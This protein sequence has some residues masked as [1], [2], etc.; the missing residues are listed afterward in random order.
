[1]A[2]DSYFMVLPENDAMRIDTHEE[3]KAKAFRLASIGQTMVICEVIGIVVATP[4]DK[5]DA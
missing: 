2:E 5:V 3:A 1:M 4:E